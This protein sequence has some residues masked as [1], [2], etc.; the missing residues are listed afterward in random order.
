MKI[1]KK[2]KNLLGQL[3]VI[4]GVIIVVA[5]ICYSKYADE[6]AAKI[7]LKS[8]YTFTVCIDKEGNVIEDRE[9]L[10]AGTAM[11]EDFK[12]PAINKIADVWIREYLAQYT[13]K[14]LSSSKAVRKVSIDES[15]VL[16]EANNIVMVSFS[17]KPVNNTTEYFSSWQGV[18]DEGRLKCEWVVEF[19]LDNHYD[20]T[21]TVY[22]RSMLTPEDYG[23]YRYNESIRNDVEDTESDGNTLTSYVIKDSTLYVSY[24]GGESYVA[25][26]VAY[27][28]LFTK[29]S[30]N[31]SL[32]DGCYTISTTKTA[33]MYGGKS[34][35][36]EKIPVTLA[37]S[38][39]K[40]EDWITCE[41]DQIY[42]AEYMYVEFFDEKQ[43]V[44]VLAYDKSDSHEASRIYQTA[45][46]GL[47]WKVIGTGPSN[48]VIK[49]VRYIDEKIG[50]FCYEYMANN[51]SNLYMTKD[52]GKTFE[53]VI[54][55]SQ[56]LEG[57]PSDSQIA[58]KDVFKEAGVPRYD[59]KEGIITVILT[60]G[61]SAMLNNGS[62]YARYQSKDNGNT[63]EYIGQFEAGSK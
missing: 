62:T 24:N 27:D 58:W 59:S 43:G 2:T 22:V 16:D 11:S 3:C 37:Y 28:N 42:T 5:I 6:M 49:G 19:D 47:T 38:D 8:R 50:F 14:Y 32:R 61:E 18:L 17:V 31:A 30:D 9:S 63:W 34:D 60:Q 12:G 48:G 23:M 25:V 40:G 55:E 33:V 29:D 26:P 36:S 56:K 44:I 46:G 7:E 4:A 10:E 54:L 45:D 1:N 21:A 20:G 57:V 13:Q 41:I 53:K 52:G 39:N 51:E 15:R 35:G